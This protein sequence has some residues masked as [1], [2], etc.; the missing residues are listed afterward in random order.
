MFAPD[1]NWDGF[2]PGCWMHRQAT[3]LGPGFFP[4]KRANADP[5]YQSMYKLGEDIGI[6]YLPAIDAAQ[7]TPALGAGDTLMVLTPAAGDVRPEVKAAAEFLA[8]PYGLKRGIDM[9]TGSPRTRPL[10]RSGTSPTSRR[11]RPTSWPTP[12]ASAST[13]LT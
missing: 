6:F 8:T 5:N 3:W 4:D 13:H 7:G 9:E 2:T 1:N 11:S 12:R 10:P